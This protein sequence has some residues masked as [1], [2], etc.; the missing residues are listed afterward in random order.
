MP[1]T[2]SYLKFDYEKFN[3]KNLMKI[4]SK[5]KDPKK[6]KILYISTYFP[7]Y[8]RSETILNLF[9]KLKI[10]YKPL[11]VGKSNYLKAIYNLIKHQKNYDLVFVAFRGHEI[12]PFIKLFTRKPIIFDAFISVYDTLCF[13]RKKIKP[14]SLF[15]RLLKRYDKYLCKRSDIVLVDTKTHSEY[16][17]KEFN[18][19]NI[20]YLYVGCNKKLFMPLKIKEKSKKFTV[21]WYGSSNPLQ[22]AKVILKT[23]KKLESKKNVIFKLVGPLRKKYP[24]LIKKLNLKN[25]EFIDYIGYKSLPNEINKSDLCLGGHFS[26]INKAKRV[27]AGKTF[28]FLTCNKPTI[29]GDCKS[30][31]ELFDENTKNVYFVK[32]NNSNYLAKKILEVKNEK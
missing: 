22:G 19:K 27:I 20:D 2:P 1:K 7:N 18:C 9:D 8:T 25:V 28:Q 23:A 3:K 6:I 31:R 4:L 32:M 13:D 14:N 10:K 24:K 21:F 11:L 16:F 15:G 17:K 12:L 30:N 26:K 29:V 5:F